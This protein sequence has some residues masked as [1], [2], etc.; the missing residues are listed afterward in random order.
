LKPS[1]ETE[2][3]PLVLAYANTAQ[4]DKASSA[5]GE[6]DK[7]VRRYICY[8]QSPNAQWPTGYNGELIRSVLCGNK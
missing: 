5:A 4:T 7:S 3:M 1:D 2:W 8:Q 6:I